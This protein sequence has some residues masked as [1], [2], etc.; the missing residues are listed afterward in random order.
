MVRRDKEGAIL[1]GELLY[2]GLRGEISKLEEIRDGVVGL[3]ISQISDYS[4]I[5]LH[6]RLLCVLPET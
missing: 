3:L 4:T 2:L 1:A 5:A 6:K